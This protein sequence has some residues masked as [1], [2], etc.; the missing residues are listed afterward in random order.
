MLPTGSVRVSAVDA[1]SGA[2]IANFCVDST[3]SNGTGKVVIGDLPARTREFY[4]YTEDGSYLYAGTG[5]VQVKANQ[6]V[7]VTIRLRP[8]ARITT[9]VVDRS[10]GRPVAGVCVSALAVRDPRMPDGYGDCTD[11]AG[12]MTIGPLEAGSYNLLADPHGGP[13]GLQWVGASGGTGDQR[14][15]VTVVA[16]AGTTVAGPQVR[17]DKAGA[18]AGRVTDAVTGAPLSDA[19][20]NLLSYSP[21][22]GSDDLITDAD[23]RY[24]VTGLGP[25]EWP[26][27][28]RH[29]GH[30]D[31][32]SGGVGDRY[33]ATRI[34]VPAG[35]TATH[36]TALTTGTEVRG[37]VTDQ[38]ARPLTSGFVVVHNATTGDIMGVTWMENGR[39]TMRVLGNQSIYLGYR[40]SDGE[41]D[42]EGSYSGPPLTR[43]DIRPGP[44]AGSG[45]PTARPGADRSSTARVPSAGASPIGVGNPGSVPRWSGSPPPS[46][47]PVPA[48][49][50]LTVNIVIH[51]D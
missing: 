29:D 11:S 35:G 27:L 17:L 20:V 25:Y 9:T 47:Y 10:T 30:A 51:T 15:A 12:K 13:Y 6:T 45:P 37:T 46:L 40:V 44:D 32:W 23:G 28:F 2:A 8:A 33:E 42:Y 18:I 43:T 34:R 41:R 5:P 49:G 48:T 38:D 50:T 26:L 22:A 19:W 4:A 16:V 7:D 14:S 36:D 1:V 3:C 31:Q 21:G 39:Y 24:R